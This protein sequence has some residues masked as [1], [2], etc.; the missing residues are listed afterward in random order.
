MKEE[1]AH[2]QKPFVSSLH[3]S[4]PS[5]QQQQQQQQRVN[6]Q[7]SGGNFRP[8][9]VKMEPGVEA[10]SG[11]SSCSRPAL[12]RQY[13][14]SSPS[15]TSKPGSAGSGK[16]SGDTAG[17]GKL[18]KPRRTSMDLPMHLP[19][20]QS[21]TDD[22]GNDLAL[23]VDDIFTGKIGGTPL[24]KPLEEEDDEE[25]T[26]DIV[27][28]PSIATS[29][30]SN[31]VSS[32]AVRT[33]VNNTSTL[34]SNAKPPPKDTEL[35]KELDLFSMVMDKVE[36]VE[37][38][39]ERRASQSSFPFPPP[40]TITPAPTQ[41]SP[42]HLI[43]P[44]P[45][46]STAQPTQPLHSLSSNGQH[47]QL[48]QYLT[49]AT[50]RQPSQDSTYSSLANTHPSNTTTFAKPHSL[51]LSE[52]LYAAPPSH[53]QHHHPTSSPHTP[54]LI[55]PTTS[56]ILPCS[57]S[58]PLP[59]TPTTPY[60]P[61]TAF[62]HQPAPPPR[63]SQIQPSSDYS[64]PLNNFSTPQPARNQMFSYN[65]AEPSDPSWNQ[66]NVSYHQFIPGKKRPISSSQYMPPAKVPLS[67]IAQLPNGNHGNQM[68]GHFL[69][70]H[71]GVTSISSYPNE[72]P[73][74]PHM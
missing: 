12:T 11:E 60:D 56:H 44:P 9:M 8:V 40:G 53:L 54:V 21:S 64:Q 48:R 29:V 19:M 13:S 70:N 18:P 43:S 46:T 42:I 35:R 34:S 59:P 61:I 73:P 65:M 63:P 66:C 51:P 41:G 57:S 26:P 16:T 27:Q 3:S 30:S 15:A 7:S 10:S 45:Y 17:K 20:A 25:H 28:S 62:H 69:T 5:G 50:T 24:L 58:H 68:L 39:K 72:P 4:C 14:S 55:S 31:G 67:T 22:A 1:S 71:T 38:A 32:P 47:T 2:E 36:R 33:H 49:G 52:N 37:K 23:T 6:K 74:Y